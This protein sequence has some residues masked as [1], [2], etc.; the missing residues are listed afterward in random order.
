MGTATVEVAVPVPV[1]GTFSYLVPEELGEVSVGVRVI[2]PFGRRT[3]TGAVVATGNAVPGA[4]AT[5]S[6]ERASPEQLKPISRVLDS[7]P[8]FDEQFL[9]LARW[10]SATY[11]SPLGEVLS[12]MLPGARRGKDLPELTGDEPETEPDRIVLSDEQEAAIARITGAAKTDTEAWY[13]LYGIT[14]SGKTEVFLR[15]AEQ[16]IA[17]RRSVLYLVPEI[18][19][20]HQLFEHISRRFGGRVAMLHSGLTPSQRLGEWQRVRRGEALLVVG[21]RSAVFAPVRDLGLVVID[22]EH[23]SSYK[24]GTAP[25]YHARQVALWRARRAGAACVMGSATPSVEAWHLMQAGRLQRIDLTRRLSGGALPAIRV[26]NVRGAGTLLSP[27]LKD[28]LVETHAMG[29]QS[30]LFLNRRGYAGVFQCRSCGYQSD[31]PKC[32]VPMT[33][34]K[35]QGRM[36]CHYCGYRTKPITVCPEC[37]SLDVGY[38]GFG[39]ERI[40][41]DLTRELP[42]M[43]IARLDTDVTGKRGALGELLDRFASGEIDVLL[44]TQ[45]VAKGLNFPRVRTVGIVMADTGLSLPDFRAAERTFALIVQVAGRAGRFRTDGEVIVQTMRPEHPAILQAVRMDIEGFYRDELAVRRELRFP[46]F[47]RLL[48]LVIRSSRRDHA[49]NAADA[50]AALLRQRIANIAG[51]ELLGPAPAPLERINRNWRYQI[52]LRGASAGTLVQLVASVRGEITRHRGVYT[53]LDVDPV[54]LL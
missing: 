48:R 33:Y 44:G 26:E 9:E 49:E 5:P 53:E 17:A 16:M 1:D 54:Q 31:C 37:G 13:Y 47:S 28:A 14:G 43:R 15:V 25:R 18:A 2:V 19:L 46:P 22:E 51:V 36:V 8:L 12:A 52:I 50:I 21:A 23:E 29:A 27:V 6:S 41:E 42:N 3:V 40:E 7:V 20:T 30:I 38:T 39:T 35:Q 32:S 24:A 11:L 4:P 10:V 45:M 34:H